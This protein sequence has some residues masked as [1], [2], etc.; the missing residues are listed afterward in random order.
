MVDEPQTGKTDRPK[1]PVLEVPQGDRTSSRT[2][3][4]ARLPTELAWK[5]QT[6]MGR[7]ATLTE[8]TEALPDVPARTSLEEVAQFQLLIEETHKAFIKEHAYFEVSWPSALTHHEYFSKNARQAE[9]RCY[10]QAR[11]VIGVLRHALAA[12]QPAQPAQPQTSSSAGEDRRTHSRLPDISLPKF[13]GEYAA[14]PAFRDLFTSLILSNQQLTDVER[15]HYLRSS[16]EGAP[17]Q[18]IS[19]LSMAGDSLTPSWD[20]LKDRYENKR[21]LIHACLDKIF[22][23]STPVPRKA[24]ALDKLVSG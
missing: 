14:W 3:S 18:L 19:G 2:A 16:L 5:V 21:R 4:P 13:T 20:L 8:L 11:R 15:L 23:S 1:T 6:Q 22:A 24:S 9:S 10:M 7:I 12:A 17:A